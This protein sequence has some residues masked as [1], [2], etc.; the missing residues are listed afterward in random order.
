MT[1]RAQILEMLIPIFEEV[2]ETKDLTLTFETVAKDVQG[3][4]SLN[5]ATL[6]A[7]VQKRLNVRF[8][9]LDVVKMKTVGDLCDLVLAHKSISG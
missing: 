6:I 7:T 4:D 3:W 9:L 1:E 5:H 8:R 2:L